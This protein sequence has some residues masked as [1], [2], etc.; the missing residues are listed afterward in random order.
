MYGRGLLLPPHPSTTLALSLP[1]GGVLAL[2]VQDPSP[3]FIG[4]V[5]AFGLVK[6]SRRVRLSMLSGHTTVLLPQGRGPSQPAGQL[7][8]LPFFHRS[9]R[10]ICSDDSAANFLPQGRGLS[11]R[12]RTPPL[13]FIDRVLA[14]SRTTVWKF[15]EKSDDGTSF[16]RG[17]VRAARRGQLGPLP[18]FI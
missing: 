3:F 4:R 14:Y 15:L 7:G 5:V 12:A 16:P 11:Q 6:I 2:A 18:F 1:R 17:G 13:F 8:P 10:R 9:V